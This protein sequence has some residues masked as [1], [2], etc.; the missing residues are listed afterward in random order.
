MKRSR[1][2]NTTAWTKADKIKAI[3]RVKSL[4]AGGLSQNK[5]R[6]AVASEYNMTKAGIGYWERTVGKTNKKT[7]TKVTKT[8]NTK[9]Y[10]FADMATDVRGI[11]K[12]IVNKDE[13]YSTQE[14]SV[15]GKL[16]SAELHRAKLQLEMHKHNS[17]TKND[18]L[19][20]LT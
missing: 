1:L 15:V 7:I 14:A 9:E 8:V 11:I 17:K 2:N 4:I 16:Y 20:S 12:S 19:I 18:N 3:S 13:R 10:T 5:A 6:A